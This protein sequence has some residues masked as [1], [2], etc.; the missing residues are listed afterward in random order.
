MPSI[1]L[2]KRSA[3]TQV[4]VP[5]IECRY[6]E[7][8]HCI[9]CNYGAG[10]NIDQTD[11]DAFGNMLRTRLEKGCNQLVISSYG[12]LLDDREISDEKLVGLLSKL[13]GLD[14]GLVILET[15]CYTVT[16]HK[17]DIIKNTLPN[18]KID[19]EMGLET[20]NPYFLESIVHKK[21]DLYKLKETISLIHEYGFGVELNILY[22]IPFLTRQEQET[23]MLNSVYWAFSNG[24][25]MVVLFPMNIRPNTTLWQLHKL[26]KYSPVSHSDFIKAVSKIPVAYLDK[27]AISCYG[28]RQFNG[29][30]ADSIPPLCDKLSESEIYTWYSDFLH[31]N[32]SKT[33]K[34]MLNKILER[35]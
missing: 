14:I 5:S 35:F 28:D 11:I 2:I 13:T 33:R 32:N 17:L 24:A 4:V 26:G 3:I 16:K 23:D 7:T 31:T 34:D 1:E 20:S 12:S 10:S 19:I 21:L 25:D 15:H 9:E 6:K 22:G 8:G 27:V 29:L 30:E 18:F